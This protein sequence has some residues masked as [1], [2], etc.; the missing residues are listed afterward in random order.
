[1]AW[2]PDGDMLITERAGRLRIVRG[3]RLLPEPVAGTPRVR[4][5]GQG[6]LLD[7]VLHPQ[8]ATNRLVY[9]SF[10]KPNADASQATTAVVRGRLENDRL[11]D[12]QEIFEAKAW[13]SGNAHFAG[14][15]AFDRKGFLYLSVGDRGESPNLMADQP[16]Q[17]LSQHQGKILRLHDDGRVPSDNPFVGRA[18]AQPE[19]WSWGHRNPQGLTV[20]PGTGEIWVNEHGP[21]G[22]DEVNRI[23]RGANFGWPVVSHGINYDGS[24]Y[25]GE[26][27]R[28]GIVEPTWA[29]VPSIATSGMLFYTGDRFPW[30]RGGL[31]VGGLVGQQLSHL[32]LAGNRVVSQEALLVDAIGRI[33]DVRQGPDGYIYLAVDGTN[34][35]PLTRVVRL[36]PVASDIQAPR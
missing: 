22:G 28:P 25:T 11:I 30:W 10:A 35:A 17:S 29:W 27:E 36:E 5:Q 20:H 4:A 24:P 9:L 31:F 8:F 13:A 33:R 12:V 18:G 6:G 7:V 14:R 3:G 19:L 21:R 34:A 16:A 26:T 15:M 23:Q 1:M 32:T 2:L